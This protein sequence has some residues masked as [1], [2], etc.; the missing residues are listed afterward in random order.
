MHKGGR[1]KGGKRSK[2]EGE[3]D[4]LNNSQQQDGKGKAPQQRE[5]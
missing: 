3:G 1:V 5:R 2:G 4:T